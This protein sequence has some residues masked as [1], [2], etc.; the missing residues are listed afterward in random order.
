MVPYLTEEC[1]FAVVVVVAAAAAAAAVAVVTGAS[2]W[3]DSNHLQNRSKSQHPPRKQPLKRRWQRPFLPCSAQERTMKEKRMEEQEEQNVV[4]VAAVLA[5]PSLAP[6]PP[7]S[8]PLHR[9]MC[10]KTPHRRRFRRI[11]HQSLRCVEVPL[12]TMSVAIDLRNYDVVVLAVLVHLVLVLVLDYKKRAVP[13]AVSLRHSTNRRPYH[14][15][16]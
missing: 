4:V 12:V 14:P 15:T 8:F 13:S 11:I 9:P 1:R 7:L 16:V 2:V 6:A 10:Q 3:E 5:V